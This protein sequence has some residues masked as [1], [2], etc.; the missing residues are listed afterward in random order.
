LLRNLAHLEILNGIR[1]EREALFE[2]DSDE[3]EGE[4]EESVSP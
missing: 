4:G 1:V 3:E 2:E